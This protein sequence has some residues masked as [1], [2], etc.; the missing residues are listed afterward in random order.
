MEDYYQEKVQKEYPN[1]V[2]MKKSFFTWKELFEVIVD[3][4]K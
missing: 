2:D 3:K 1:H 4:K